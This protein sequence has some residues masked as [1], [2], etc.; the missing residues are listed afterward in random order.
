MVAGYNLSLL[1]VYVGHGHM[2]VK[3]AI[4]L[5]RIESVTPAGEDREAEEITPPLGQV[6]V[7][8]QH[9]SCI[10]VIFIV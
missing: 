5:P 2:P 7:S 4:F 9:A 6:G 1:Y 3:K 8:S 10:G